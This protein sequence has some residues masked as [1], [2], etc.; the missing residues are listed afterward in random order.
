[1]FDT[2]KKKTTG[3]LGALERKIKELPDHYAIVREKMKD[4]TKTN[5]ELGFRHLE[6]GNISDA[7]MRFKM[8]LRWFGP[9]HPPAVYG[10][11]CCRKEEGNYEDAIRLFKQA[12]ELKNNDYPEAEY[13]LAQIDSS[14]VPHTIPL[15]MLT[16]YFNKQAPNFNDEY[17]G[18]KHF[19]GPDLLLEASAT[20]LNKNDL[21]ML[22]LGC[23]TGQCGKEFKEHKLAKEITGV[24]I[25]KPMLAQARGLKQNYRPVYD[26]LV[27]KDMLFYLESATAQHFD[28]ITASLVFHYQ[29]DLAKLLT[30]CK[31]VLK[32]G[33]VILFTARKAEHQEIEF[34]PAQTMFAVSLTHLESQAQKA[35]LT[36]IHVKEAMIL[37]ECPGYVCAFK[38]D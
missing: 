16:S 5:T 27:E 33:A 30:A 17:F 19:R 23:G 32:P 9:D 37:D 21:I 15:A 36:R 4:L 3:L 22:D 20:V 2:L 7:V 35:G 12:I 31:K 25:S 28:L 34:V 13:A 11:A 29:S 8:V 14:V 18:N 26:H 24:D 6:L 38:N 10:L 1:M